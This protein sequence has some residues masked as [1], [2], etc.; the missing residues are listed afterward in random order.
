M[1][2]IG[3]TGGMGS[4]KSIVSRLL[5]AAGI[6]VYLTD[7]E[8]KRLMDTDTELRARLRMLV[9]DNI[10]PYEGVVNRSALAHW[11]FADRKR[12][13]QVN[14]IVHPFVRA[15]FHRWLQIYAKKPI[16]AIESAILIEAGFVNEVD[17]VWLV[18]AP[19]EVRITRSMERDSSTREQV[20]ARM[21]HQASDEGKIKY[22]S[23]TLVNDGE[24]PLMPQVFRHIS[25]PVKK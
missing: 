2:I 7:D 24:T 8:A 3:I 22:A 19:T 21:Q 1:K 23:I 20:L 10:C 9:G 17:E 13:A 5:L 18:T 16:T 12:V 11:L 15:S 4:G 6:P 25:F 14:A